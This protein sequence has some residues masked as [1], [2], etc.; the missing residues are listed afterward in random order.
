MCGISLGGNIV[1]HAADR[2]ADNHSDKK[3]IVSTSSSPK[4]GANLAWHL[5]RSLWS[6]EYKNNMM[7]QALNPVTSKILAILATILSPIIVPIVAL[8]NPLPHIPDLS[9]KNIKTLSIQRKNDNVVPL[10]AQIEFS[11]NKSSNNVCCKESGSHNDRLGT[12]AQTSL[13]DQ[14]GSLFPAQQNSGNLENAHSATEQTTLVSPFEPL[15]STNQPNRI[16][17]NHNSSN[18]RSHSIEESHSRSNRQSSNNSQNNPEHSNQRAEP[19][20]SFQPIF[21]KAPTEGSNKRLTL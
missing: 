7:T 2:L 12:K 10:G 14:Y 6:S 1:T 8:I 15:P 11:G 16:E 9:T 17:S 13:N 19:S 20:K 18:E 4:S 5:Y 21:D 3:I